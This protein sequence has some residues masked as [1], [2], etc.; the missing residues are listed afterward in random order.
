M[1]IQTPFTKQHVGGFKYRNQ[2][3]NNDPNVIREEGFGIF[4]LDENNIVVTNKGVS[5]GSSGFTVDTGK[6]PYKFSNITRN[7]GAKRSVN[8]ENLKSLVGTGSVG[9]YGL[10]YF[11]CFLFEYQLHHCQFLRRNLF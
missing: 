6:A 3:I 4:K 7:V 9:N 2:G 11:Y 10:Q 5:S 1:S 8:I